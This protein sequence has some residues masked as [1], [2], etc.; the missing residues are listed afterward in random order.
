MTDWDSWMIGFDTDLV[1]T[2]WVGYDQNEKFLTPMRALRSG[3][4][5]RSCN[6]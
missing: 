5:A 3:C 1:T 6:A 4:G 2:V